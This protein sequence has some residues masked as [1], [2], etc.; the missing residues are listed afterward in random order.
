M[1]R[2]GAAAVLDP[3]SIAVVGASSDPRK[4][5]YQTIRR[6]LAD[7]Y[8]H[9][10]YPVNPRE[11]RILDL[12]TYPT[13]AAIGRPV[14]LALIV[15]PAASAPQV[16]AECGAAGITAVI[17]IAVG[18]GE[19]GP[20]GK[21]LEEEL[22]R[23]ADDHGVALLGP[24]TNGVFNVHR[25]LNLLGTTDVPEGRLSLLCQSG[26]VG[27]GLV[28]QVKHKTTLGLC[29]YAGIG[30]EAGLRFDELLD[31]LATDEHTSVILVYAE[32][33]RDGRRFL[34]AARAV[35]RETPVVLYKAG[36]S[37]AARRSATSHTGA[38][39][40]PHEV[41]T[42]VLRQAGIQVVERSDELV[43]VASVLAG[44]PP[45][46]R[47]GVA[48]LAD[49]GGHATVAADALD[50]EGLDLPPVAAETRRRLRTLLPPAAATANPIDVAGAT[51][52]D[53]SIF[54]DCLEVL[55]ADP[56]VDGVLCVGLLGGYG[57]RFSGDLTDVE[58]QTALRMA[59]LAEAHHKALVVQ[60]AYA[61]DHP[62]AHGLLRDA[63]VPVLSSV[64]LAARCVAALHERGRDLA[65]SPDRS[66]FG[67]IEP[68]TSTEVQRVLTEPAGRD[69]LSGAGIALDRW[70]LVGDPEEAA[71]AADR[72]GG[73]VALKIVSADIVHKTDVGGVV[74]GIVGAQAA[75][76]ACATLLARVRE[77]RPE[78]T[79]EGVLVTPMAP[80]GVELLVGATVDA[81]FGPVL[82]VGAGGTLVE[83]HPD[84]AFRALPVTALEA[85]E[86]LAELA[87]APLLDGFRGSEPVDRRAVIDLLVAVSSLV[88][89]DPDLVELDL[90]PVIAHPGG[91]VA[92]DVRVVL[93]GVP[94]RHPVEVRA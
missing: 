35:T 2:S 78:A 94:V 24:N 48:V 34:Q 83:L 87:L 64:E 61:Y 91:V 42:A 68:R 6:L 17:V 46:T 37:A 29:C 8:P 51:D 28:T 57:I 36:R 62:R 27:L 14:D 74:L 18:F 31:H 19:V 22:V 88:A 10:I 23:A 73:P 84:V 25:R 9:P 93:A 39:A 56:G 53:P 1:T 90:N 67:S 52:G 75:A 66:R 59:R 4:R 20:D 76:Q 80:P 63:G 55:L 7:G 11:E 86:M 38:V 40:G 21:R 82:T 49:G 5:G 33:F 3:T 89:H 54:A 81:T 43:P 32:A 69:R 85:E 70:D 45:M 26:N 44:Q 47:G 15:T 13:V 65:R 50:R 58:E 16:V 12:P 72:I 71:E 92:V 30:N 79:L 77:A 41:A 60:S